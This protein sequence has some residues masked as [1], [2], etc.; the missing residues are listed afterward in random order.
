M[1][2]LSREVKGSSRAFLTAMLVE[3]F[4]IVSCG[5]HSWQACMGWRELPAGLCGLEVSPCSIP[6]D[7]RLLETSH[8]SPFWKLWRFA[9]LKAQHP[10]IEAEMLWPE[11]MKNSESPSQTAPAVNNIGD[12]TWPH[13]VPR[14]ICS[15][16]S[17]SH[18]ASCQVRAECMLGNIAFPYLA[19][20]TAQ[21][22]AFRSWP[23]WMPCE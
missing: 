7:G 10:E 1:Y 5:G 15:I 12:K 9:K 19:I 6:W 11:D 16:I 3:L 13:S 22:M 18:Y 14:A 4:R 8:E 23:R 20:G 21:V 17:V 2:S